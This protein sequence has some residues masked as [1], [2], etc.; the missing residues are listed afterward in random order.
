MKRRPFE[1]G[2]RCGVR[3]NGLNVAHCGA[4]HETFTSP[5]GFDAHRRIG[6]CRLPSECGL[7]PKNRAGN[8]MWGFPDDGRLAARRNEEERAQPGPV[9]SNDTH[10]EEDPS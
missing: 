1:A 9:T 5:N 2:C 7:E 3:W 10:V 8:Y 6:E 4:C